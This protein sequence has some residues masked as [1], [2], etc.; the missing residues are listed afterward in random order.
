MLRPTFSV[1]RKNAL[2]AT[3]V[4][5]AALL[6]AAIASAGIVQ[7]AQYPS[8]FTSSTTVLENGLGQRALGTQEDQFAGQFPAEGTAL[9][10]LRRMPPSGKAE[11]E[12]FDTVFT[13]TDASGALVVSMYV[14][15]DD[16]VAV[17][18][19]GLNFYGFDGWGFWV[20][21]GKE[22]KAGQNFTVGI[23]WGAAGF[24]V[25]LDGLLLD[26][27]YS[28]FKG[29][30]FTGTG[31]DINKLLGAQNIIIG[32]D[33]LEG[34]NS[35]MTTTALQS[36]EIHDT[37]Y[38]V[39]VSGATGAPE[40]IANIIGEA[41]WAGEIAISWTASP[42]TSVTEY[43]IYRGENAAP[44][45]AG[46]PLATT[47]K[48]SYT[49]TAIIPGVTYQYSVIA[50]DAAGG[51]SAAS[52][53][54]SVTAIAGDGP[55]ISEISTDTA[56]RPVKPGATVTITVKGEPGATASVKIGELP[57]TVALGEAGATGVYSG[58]YTITDADV[59]ASTA[60]HLI[61]ALLTDDYGSSQL[62]GPQLAIVGQ[63]VLDDVTA[64]V[65]SGASHDGYSVAGFSGT[66]VAGDI[67]TV[68]LTG[69]AGGF[70]SFELKGTS[71]T[72]Q[73]AETA[74]G[75]YSGSYTI[76]WEDAGSDIAV[77][78]TLA[79]LAGNESKS[80]VGKPLNIDTRV[81]L[82]VTAND[83]LLPADQAAKTRIIVRAENA[84]GD[85]VS[86]HELALTLST[87]EEY[88]GVVGGGDVEGRK[89]GK[90][91]IDDLEIKWGGVT[92]SFGEIAA[93]YTS[94]FAAKTALIIAK[95]LTTGD[96]G[97]GWLNTYV[98]STIAIELIPASAKAGALA[99]IR[100]SASPSW[101]T[102]DG[103]SKTRIRAWLTD[104]GGAPLAGERMRFSVDSDNGRVKLIS[105]VTDASGMAEAEYR[106]GTL[107]GMVTVS[108]NAP[109][110]GV[111]S[112]IQVELR[113]DAPA[114]IGLSASRLSLP[115]DGTSTS[116][117]RAVVTDINDNPN[118]QAPLTYSIVQG[119]GSISPKDAT[120]DD[121][122]VSI[123][124]YTAGKSAG[125]ALVEAR[126]TS[127]APND[128]ELNRIQGT[129]FVPRLIDG[130]ERERIRVDEWLVE[131][132]DSVTKGQGLVKISMR[133]QEWTLKA[134]YDGTLIRQVRFHR[135]RVEL[136]DTVGYMELDAAAWEA[137]NAR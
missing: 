71:P 96:I 66:L 94:G 88:T 84:N 133:G 24:D 48:L 25:Y 18:G 38:S 4:F 37:P 109:D 119:G 130:Q 98:A 90:D 135:D 34:D 51:R 5:I 79:D 36:Y 104:A 102:A 82:V 8:G 101:L 77:E 92:D 32:R 105:G 120:T 67:I 111:S 45:V 2:T 75:V 131:P 80:A 81:R 22:I 129:I 49:D 106:A 28:S 33:L 53:T 3:A 52:D 76:G 50:V 126:H 26:K 117:I 39:A 61:V 128:G 54:V 89:A 103:R 58:S 57:V 110:Q 63:D 19:S 72:V 97:V 13:L 20:P 114:K 7:S 132:G 78:A 136:G 93:N 11:L 60:S 41:P 122:G 115:A 69:E 64:P 121:S 43:E 27:K 73:M 123:A 31:A 125:T 10:Q 91:D 40:A 47:G 95:D 1:I 99:S 17:G 87:T 16:G 124:T 35:P 116:D 15:W 12:G 29:G 23:S 113:S 118:K 68:E 127:R 108:A 6:G 21:F 46:V 59:G 44:A 55:A 137:L 107:A 70:A 85:D 112:S 134:A 83:T 56:G 62:A 42:T 9:F 86:G 14:V 65:I 30:Q 100:M 74:P